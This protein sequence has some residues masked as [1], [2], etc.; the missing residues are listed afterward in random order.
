MYDTDGIPAEVDFKFTAA[1]RTAGDP[2]NDTAYNCP[3]EDVGCPYTLWVLC[4]FNVTKTTEERVRFM[5]C[6]DDSCLGDATFSCPEGSTYCECA[7][8][9]TGLEDSA[10]KCSEAAK[11]D[12]AAVSKC[13]AS[14]GATL[15]H[16]A[17]VA[18]ETKWPENAHEGHYNV[19]HVL[20][21]SKDTQGN[22]TVAD[23]LGD[24]CIADVQAACQKS[25]VEIV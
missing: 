2:A 14:G 4:A 20:I 1:I 13:Q 24:L 23:L 25:N 9:A 17:A 3:D 5:G 8:N 10:Q 22:T 7:Q 16:D 6:W 15:L 12:F 21:A 19:P 18:F 11:L